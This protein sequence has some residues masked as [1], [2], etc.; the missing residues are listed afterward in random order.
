H[1]DGI[2]RDRWAW[3]GDA[4]QSYWMNFYTFFDEDVNNGLSKE[5]IRSMGLFLKDQRMIILIVSEFNSY[6]EILNLKNKEIIDYKILFS[7][8]VYKNFYAE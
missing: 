1:L 5:F 4:L 8:I 7:M 3:S 2:K 6:L